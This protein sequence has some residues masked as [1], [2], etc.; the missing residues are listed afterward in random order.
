MKRPKACR[1]VSRPWRVLR[2]VLPAMATGFPLTAHAHPGHGHGADGTGAEHY[3]TEPI[4]ALPFW[5]V[6][7][8]AVVALLL[9]FAT[10]RPAKIRSNR[11]G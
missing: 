3:L 9:S 11:A 1:S 10:L 5:G 4:H 6:L 8:L 2:V 7:A